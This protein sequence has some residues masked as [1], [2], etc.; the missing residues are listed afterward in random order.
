MHRVKKKSYYI[1]DKYI[2]EV[3]DRIRKN[4]RIRRPLPGWGK[5]HIDRKLPFICIY[6]KSGDDDG[7]EKF[8]TTG[9]SFIIA[10]DKAHIGKSLSKLIY[11][12]V[13]EV[14]KEFKAFLIVELWSK[15]T[16]SINHRLDLPKPRF[17]IIIGEQEYKKSSINS[18]LNILK[19]GLDKV[20]ILKQHSRAEI[21]YTKNISPPKL[22]PIL[23]KKDEKKLKCHVIGVEIN[24]VYLNTETG[25]PYPA[26]ARKLSEQMSYVFQQAFFEFMNKLTTQNV[27]HYHELGKS[28]LSQRVIEIDKSFAFLC[29]N[30]DFLK[31]ATPINEAQA[32]REFQ[33]N[34]Y[35]KEPV[36]Y[37]R[38]VPFDHTGF[39]KKL[40]SVPIEEIEDPALA[41]LFVDKREEL[42]IKVSM[43]S[44][45]DS[46]LFHYGSLQLYGN[47]N[48]E[49]SRLASRLLSVLPVHSGRPGKGYVD[50]VKFREYALNEISKYK[51][52]YKEFMASVEVSEDM[53]SGLLVSQSKL[54]IGKEFKIPRYRVDALL[55]HEVGTH[56]VTYFNGL[57]QPF[58]LLHIG[59][60][61]YDELQEGLAVLAEFLV[62]GLSG[63]R[64]RMLSARVKAAEHMINGA[65]F[66]ET[67]R[68]L[69][70][71]Y[72]FTS[73]M[74]FTIVMRIYRGGGLTKD[75]IYL[76]GFM[77][78]LEYIKS[79]GDIE[80]LYVGKISASN[81]P[82]VNELQLRGILKPTPL[83]PEFYSRSETS[84]NLEKLKKPFSLV[85]YAGKEAKK[86]KR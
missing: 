33:R 23:T 52:K 16:N 25:T 19:D 78:I 70:K 32:R 55:Q 49:L 69:V 13:E 64:L 40:W 1:T 36:F 80:K 10:S 86:I 43:L 58:S 15:K 61:G 41:Q 66:V 20:T 35:D 14:S 45:L 22:K 73:S 8:V 54:H 46:P 26:I 50:A 47:V 81:I 6:R 65:G 9:A 7:T 21:V 72:G 5:I 76:R 27:A 18:T 42:D 37:Y 24:P 67:F 59:F 85:S 30:F 77:E 51:E 53:F 2:D 38:P 60:A 74:A 63:S 34:K 48:P 68:I 83:L 79:G 71:E 39:K 82:V 84:K 29:N 17:R 3:C 28:F 62:D 75:I 31:L 56:L 12:V 44:N 4:K 11:K 57:A